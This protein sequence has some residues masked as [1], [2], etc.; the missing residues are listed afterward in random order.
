MTTECLPLKIATRSAL[1]GIVG[2]GSA[3]LFLARAF[4]AAGFE[5]V[6]F[7][8]DHSVGE[9]RPSPIRGEKL[10]LQLEFQTTTETQRLKE[11]DALFICTSVRLTTSRQPDLTGVTSWIE[12][13]AGH[14]RPGQL[15]VLTLPLPPGTTRNVLRS[16]LSSGGR[17][18]GRDFFLAYSPTLEEHNCKLIPR[19][20]GASDNVSLE[21]AM[22]VFGWIDQPTIPVSSLE[23]AELRGL[24]PAVRRSVNEAWKNELKQVCN[25]MLLNSEEVLTAANDLCDEPETEMGGRSDLSSIFLCWGVRRFGAS[26]RLISLSEEINTSMPAFVVEKVTDA[27]N[28]AGKPVRGSQVLILGTN[29]ENRE[30]QLV[31]YGITMKNLL[32][33]KGAAVTCYGSYPPKFHPTNDRPDQ[34]GPSTSITLEFLAAQD[35]VIIVGDLMNCDWRDIVGNSRLVIDTRNVT[36]EI[37]VGCTKIVRI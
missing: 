19:V 11:P 12:K 14:L 27:L 30:T 9:Q 1:I 29:D 32:I 5:V 6:I 31:S 37:P 26:A 8:D 15:I 22:A 35:C 20:V 10:N 17:V 28:D 23:V 21:A 24:L 7:E 33:K 3:G 36:K 13:L 25:Q 2:T 34:S 4:Q 18:P 16:P